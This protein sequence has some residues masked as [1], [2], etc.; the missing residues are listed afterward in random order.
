MTTPHSP[1]NQE[2]SASATGA[3][4]KLPIC[5][6][7]VTHE[8]SGDFSLPDY[9]PEIKRLLRIG[10]SPLPP[11][12]FAGRDGVE[13]SGGMYYFVLYTGNDD[14]LYCAPLTSEYTLSVP[15]ASTEPSDT[16]A[17]LEH[18]MGDE[19]TC[20][21]DLSADAVTGR[22]TAPRRL[23]IRCR[24]TARVKAYATCP[25]GVSPSSVGGESPVEALTHVLPCAH[26]LRGIGDVLTLQDCMLLSPAEADGLRVVCAEGRVMPS[27]VV[28]G[29]GTVTCRGDVF[30][31]L[32][33]AHEGDIAPTAVSVVTRKLP[34]AQAVELEGVTPDCTACARGVCAHLS[35][36]PAEDQLCTELGLVL[37]VV[38]Q[39][40]VP[41]PYTKDLYAVGRATGTEQAVYALEE[42]LGCRSGNFTLSHSLPVS[43]ISLP[44]TAQVLDVTAVATPHELSEDKGKLRLSGS[45]HLHVLW[46]REGELGASELDAPFRYELDGRSLEGIDRPHDICFCGGAQ[47]ISCRARMDGERLSL[48]AEISVMLSLTR[49]DRVTALSHAVAGQPLSRSRGEYVICFPAPDDTLWSV[50]KRYNAP[51][52]P[53]AAANGLASLSTPDD[54]ASLD[55]V[56]YLIV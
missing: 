30:L 24:L 34:F 38:A 12:T 45:C 5:D 35:V 47:V 52:A 2:V 6:R 56:G 32:T 21:C 53:L 28:T 14:R 46:Q 22:V 40:N 9:Q 17:N 13:L 29:Q 16:Q 50:A 11:S 25:A 31:K 1:M 23:S 39:R 37:E 15:F 48:D 36:E 27:E 4:F 43:E 33:L 41:T 3:T 42:G 19:P 10:V 7:A 20:L 18:W 49:H 8:I 55:G 26:V 54:A 51:L 44:S